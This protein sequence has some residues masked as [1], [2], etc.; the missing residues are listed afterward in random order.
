[1]SRDKTRPSKSYCQGLTINSYGKYILSL[2]F[3]YIMHEVTTQTSPYT[4]VCTFTHSTVEIQY[5]TVLQVSVTWS[6]QGTHHQTAQVL[7]YSV[8]TLYSVQTVSCG[9]KPCWRRR[10]TRPSL[11]TQDRPVPG[12]KGL[13]STDRSLWWWRPNPILFQYWFLS[14]P[15]SKPL[16]GFL[17]SLRR[18]GSRDVLKRE[19][20]KIMWCL[21]WSHRNNYLAFE[22]VSLVTDRVLLCS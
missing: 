20:A 21:K 12:P 17:D 1:M 2:V 8:E 6:H 19:L 7:C 5:S 9:A 4:H 13:W 14:P 22:V 10:C 15:C 11:P 3:R 18:K 16:K